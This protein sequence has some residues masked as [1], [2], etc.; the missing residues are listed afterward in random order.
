[1]GFSV[2]TPGRM[3]NREE[4]IHKSDELVTTYLGRIIGDNQ[5]QKVYCY[6]P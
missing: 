6:K 1:M 3:K 2:W 4:E 5:K